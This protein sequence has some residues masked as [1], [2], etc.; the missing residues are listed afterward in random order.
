MAGGEVTWTRAYGTADLATGRPMEPNMV[1]N[2]G[3]CGKVLTAW[4]SCVWW[5][6]AGLA[7]MRGSTVT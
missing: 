3:S 2:F 5:T 1:F 7:W 4:V 6:R